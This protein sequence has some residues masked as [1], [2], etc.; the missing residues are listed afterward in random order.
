MDLD[1]VVEQVTLIEPTER[2]DRYH[3]QQ[4]SYHEDDGEEGGGARCATQ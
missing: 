1:T 4:E 2:E 3:H